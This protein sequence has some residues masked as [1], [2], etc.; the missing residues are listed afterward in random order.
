MYKFIW[1]VWQNELDNFFESYKL[2]GSPKESIVLN[3]GLDDNQIKQ[4]KSLGIEIRDIAKNG[5]LGQCIANANS[6]G[7]RV[8]EKMGQWFNTEFFD[9]TKD[10]DAIIK[11]DTDF[12][13]KEDPN[14]VYEILDY[15]YNKTSCIIYGP[16]LQYERYDVC[17]GLLEW[18]LPIA[19][20]CFAN[21]VNVY[22]IIYI[23]SSPV[24]SYNNKVLLNTRHGYH[25]GIIKIR[26]G[27]HFRLMSYFRKYRN[28][29]NL[30]NALDFYGRRHTMHYGEDL[31]YSLVASLHDGHSPFIIDDKITC[32]YL[33]DFNH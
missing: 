29:F 16:E 8:Y 15:Y 32:K 1:L 25:S 13:S 21:I 17:A 19:K 26:G 14:K 23:N 6:D 12:F 7:M 33:F 28:I 24:F 5:K 11:V 2:L 10:L 30:G 3:S 22:D 31:M 4:I 27:F 9:I 20:H 18:F